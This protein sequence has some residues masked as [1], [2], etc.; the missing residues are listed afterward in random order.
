M[1]WPLLASWSPLYPLISW[2]KSCYQKNSFSKYCQ[3]AVYISVLSQIP[4][5]LK[6]LLSWAWEKWKHLSILKPIFLIIPSFCSFLIM[7]QSSKYFHSHDKKK[8]I[9]YS[10]QLHMASHPQILLTSSFVTVQV[11][12][13]HLRKENKKEY[14]LLFQEYF[15]KAI[16][17]NKTL[18]PVDQ[19]NI[20]NFGLIMLF[21]FQ[22]Q[23]N[24]I[25][26]LRICSLKKIIVCIIFDNSS[27][28]YTMISCC[29][30]PTSF[31]FPKLCKKL[32]Q[33]RFGVQSSHR[34]SYFLVESHQISMQHSIF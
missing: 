10:C 33:S 6:T 4:Q 22:D 21:L 12:S 29:M 3:C 19:G 24:D 20:L 5:W 16:I 23:Y 28:L 25:S 18:R 30:S 17:I 11:I 9:F 1:W 34:R 27:W 13:R 2:K 7:P 31:S 26:F 32:K 14:S 8:K 15:S